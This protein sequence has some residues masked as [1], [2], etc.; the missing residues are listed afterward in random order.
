MMAKILLLLLLR[1][2]LLLPP[3]SLLLMIVMTMKMMKM[4]A[5]TTTTT[6]M[7]M[8][9]TTISSSSEISGFEATGMTW[10]SFELQTCDTLSRHLYCKTTEAAS[11]VLF[12]FLQVTSAVML[13]FCSSSDSSSSCLAL[14]PRQAVDWLCDVCCACHFTCW[15]VPLDCGMA[16]AVDPP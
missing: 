14:L 9:T 16:R 3:P 15:S 2:L 12:S 7:M 13:W 1:L 4:T 5:T 8:M 6:I 10:P 11:I